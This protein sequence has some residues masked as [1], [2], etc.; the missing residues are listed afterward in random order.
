LLGLRIGTATYTNSR[1]NPFGGRDHW[2]IAVWDAK[3]EAPAADD[4]K[5]LS[6]F[7]KDNPDLLHALTTRLSAGPIYLPPSVGLAP[8]K[9]PV[10]LN[11]AATV[12]VAALSVHDHF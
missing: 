9:P 8:A 6:D 2:T 7:L 12:D 3:L 5:N 10:P 4:Q 11:G 1:P